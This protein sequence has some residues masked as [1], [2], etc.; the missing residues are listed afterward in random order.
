MVGATDTSP[1]SIPAAP[2]GRA[3]PWGLCHA[4]HMP[5]QHLCI[6]PRELSDLPLR[7]GCVVPQ[8]EGARGAPVLQQRCEGVGVPWE[9]PQAVPL[10][11]RDGRTH[12]V[13]TGW[14][15]AHPASMPGVPAA[16]RGMGAGTCSSSS[17]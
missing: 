3:A 10:Q 13:G 11:D 12:P 16:R 15:R 17:A 1:R 5:P 8:Q 6:L 2:L 14:Q 4:R 9:H 7:L